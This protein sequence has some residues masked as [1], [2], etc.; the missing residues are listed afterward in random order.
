MP[1]TSSEMLIVRSFV[2]PPSSRAIPSFIDSVV[3]SSNT[4]AMPD[5]T[6]SHVNEPHFVAN[7]IATEHAA[8]VSR[9]ASTDGSRFS[10]D[11]GVEY[12][13]MCSSIHVVERRGNCP[14]RIPTNWLKVRRRVLRHFAAGWLGSD[15]GG[16]QWVISWFD[17]RSE[18]VT[19]CRFHRPERSTSP[20]TP[21][22]NEVALHEGSACDASHDVGRTTSLPVAW[23][24][25]GFVV[26]VVVAT[27]GEVV[28]CNI[29]IITIMSK[30]PFAKEC[31]VHCSGFARGLAQLRQ[32]TR[33]SHTPRSPSSRS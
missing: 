30:T 26:V 6:T 8:T 19:Q 17:S 21:W 15:I 24:R 5:V 27:R 12:R 10:A 2:R 13:R 18:T 22:S 7:Q 1:I 23:A 32:L 25:P 3:L 14:V 11:C 9:S 31:R 33:P 29:C 16:P 28:L 4:G 20:D